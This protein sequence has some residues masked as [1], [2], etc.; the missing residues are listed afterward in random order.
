MTTSNPRPSDPALMRKS[1]Q[2]AA[3]PTLAPAPPKNLSKSLSTSA[4]E[5]R[6]TEWNIATSKRSTAWLKP[7]S[8]TGLTLASI[9]H[10]SCF[11]K[12]HIFDGKGLGCPAGSKKRTRMP[13]RAANDVFAQ[14]GKTPGFWWCTESLLAAVWV[15]ESFAVS[16]NY[17]KSLPI[18]ICE[19]SVIGGT[20]TP[21]F[22]ALEGQA[23]E[24]SA[25]S[26][27]SV[28]CL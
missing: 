17:A 10:T 16:S 13:K 12:V 2:A 21:A 11:G 5:S 6:N 8:S 28:K 14:F 20:K 22:L 24:A 23:F 15:S 27:C 9:S 18:H 1:S 4:P 3:M 7:S 26:Y 19:S 25:T